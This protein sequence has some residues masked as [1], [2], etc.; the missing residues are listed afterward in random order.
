MRL[1]ATSRVSEVSASPHVAD[2]LAW[3]D[4]HRRQL[5][6]RAAPGRA[7][8]PYRVWLSEIMLQQTTVKAVGPYYRRFLDRFPTIREL[9]QAE[10]DD[11]LKLWAGLGYY[12]RARN[13]HGCAK[14]V[15]ERHGGRFPASEA[16]LR[17]LPGIGD[18]TAAAIAAIA[19]DQRATPVDGNIERVIARLHAVEQELPGAKPLI[20]QLAAALTPQRRAGDF[21][22]ALMDLGSTIC[23]PKQPACALCPWTN[24]CK[25]RARGDADTFPRKTPKIAGKLRRGAA[26]VVLRADGQMLVRTRAAR[27]LLGGMTEVPNSA[28]THDFDEDTALDHA[29][30]FLSLGTGKAVAFGGSVQRATSPRVHPKSGLPDFGPLSSGRSR[31]HPTSTERSAE[32]NR[33]RVRGTLSESKSSREPLTPTL[34]PQAGR[35]RLRQPTWRR[36]PGVVRHVFTHF[37]L[38]LTIYRLEV[39]AR[40]KA[41]AH[42]R[43]IAVEGLGSE[44]LPNL[45]RKV[46]THADV[47]VKAVGWV[48]RS[49]THR[50]R[51]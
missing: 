49:E 3:Y 45:M 12:A 9:A 18:Y 4:R 50:D 26:F 17:E 41:P 30:Q 42:M 43:W 51:A 15:I 1:A 5:P 14:A 32:A 28:W 23:T 13:L 7:A 22:Q 27:G 47:E 10:L 33:G 6:W 16:A 36:I 46:I 2:V 19:F 29:P 24:A 25:A 31:K 8:D 48:E 39:P 21:A 37:P 20:R 35:G 40:T 11:V 44:A 34:S 38:E